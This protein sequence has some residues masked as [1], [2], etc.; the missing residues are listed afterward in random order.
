MAG[1]ASAQDAPALPGG[2]SSLTET[3]GDWR[4]ACQLVEE[5]KHC[6]MSQQQLRQDG[7]RV[8]TIELQT[9][10]DAALVGTLVLPFGLQLDAGATL[11]VDE[12]PAMAPLSF[13][14]CLPAGCIIR[15][16]FDS[17]TVTG[18][19]AG[20]KLQAATRTADTGTEFSIAISLSG[21]TA[22][23]DRLTALSA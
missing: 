18:L 14:T 7:Q 1:P 17:E 5:A 12:Q 11:Q 21:F 3:Y 20:T 22:A 6:V 13:H 4:V 9:G 10:P 23:L 2:A 8:V 16:R 15:V 19:R